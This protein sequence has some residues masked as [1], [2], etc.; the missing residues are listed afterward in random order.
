MKNSNKNPLIDYKFIMQHILLFS[1][2]GGFRIR[3]KQTYIIILQMQRLYTDQILPFPLNSNPRLFTSLL[4]AYLILIS[5]L[6]HDL[7]SEFFN[8]SEQF[9]FSTI[10]FFKPKCPL[11]S[12]NKR[13][14]CLMC[15]QLCSTAE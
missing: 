11:L 5:T 4:L 10:C 14:C 15:S 6:K 12:N 2:E 8:H 13:R 7:F 1:V 9:F 3:Q